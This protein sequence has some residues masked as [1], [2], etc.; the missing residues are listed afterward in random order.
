MLRHNLE[1]PVTVE[2]RTTCLTPYSI[3]S[4]HWKNDFKATK[5]NIDLVSCIL[6]T[7]SIIFCSHLGMV[8][9]NLFR[10]IMLAIKREDLLY[11]IIVIIK[12]DLSGLKSNKVHISVYHKQLILIILQAGFPDFNLCVC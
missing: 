11:L 5:C 6:M 1:A 9:Y 2:F 8:T 7:V 10:V 4:S 12:P 3:Q